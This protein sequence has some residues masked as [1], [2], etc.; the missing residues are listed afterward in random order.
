MSYDIVFRK[1]QKFFPKGDGGVME[2]LGSKV[3]L[4]Y[5]IAET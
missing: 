2:V 1:F 4:S 5:R 3:G